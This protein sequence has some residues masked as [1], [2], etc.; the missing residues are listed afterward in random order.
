MA[1]ADAQA[2]SLLFN[3]LPRSRELYTVYGTEERIM[4]L[5]TMDEQMLKTILK[6]AIVEVLEERRD[7]IRDVI[8]EALEDLGLEGAIAEGEQTSLVSREVVFTALDGPA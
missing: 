3:M 6:A 5:A 1:A 8:D 2:G 4:N 7:L